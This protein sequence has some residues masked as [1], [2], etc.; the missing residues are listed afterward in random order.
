MR[1]FEKMRIFFIVYSQ[2]LCN[3]EGKKSKETTL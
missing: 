1:I 3:F 2:I